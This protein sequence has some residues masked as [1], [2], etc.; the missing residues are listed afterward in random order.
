VSTI[1]RR[2]SLAALTGATAG[3][4]GVLAPTAAT[5][6]PPAPAAIPVA[7]TAD[8]PPAT[9]ATTVETLRQNIVNIALAE[10]QN[11]SRNHE[12]GAANCNFYTGWWGRGSASGCPSGFRSEEWCADFAQ[13]VWNKSGTYDADHVLNAGS[14]S[15]KD[16]GLTYGGWHGGDTKG[17]QPGAA[18]VW[19]DNTGGGRGGHV[20]IVTKINGNDIWIVSGNY[21]NAITKHRLSDVSS[22]LTYLGYS[23]PKPR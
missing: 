19:D 11:T 22:T 1:T 16:Y 3:L 5:A 21:G 20:G 13:Y 15:F 2:R 14:R 7:P 6:A 4:A 10:L 12:S 18:V 17:I 9:P 8:E 23:S